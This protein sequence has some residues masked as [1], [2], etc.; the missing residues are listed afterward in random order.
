MPEMPLQRT[1]FFFFLVAFEPEC[2]FFQPLR[3]ASE[4]LW[5]LPTPCLSRCFPEN[6]LNKN[7]FCTLVR[8]GE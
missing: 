5:P 2:H 1:R 4:G 7:T 3:A 6:V 8:K